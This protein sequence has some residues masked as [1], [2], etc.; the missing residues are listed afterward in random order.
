MSSA[1]FAAHK[2][3]GLCT[4]RP[5]KWPRGPTNELHNAAGSGCVLHTAALLSG[6]EEFSHK[7]HGCCAKHETG[8]S[9][10]EID[11]NEGDETGTT[12][13]MYAAQYAH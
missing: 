5:P 3:L 2:R 11:I 13:L 4:G 12:P 6:D 10:G 9:A 8:T 7:G 1:C